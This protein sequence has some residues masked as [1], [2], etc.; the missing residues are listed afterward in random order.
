[1]PEDKS[2]FFYGGLFHWLFDRPLAEG[3]QVVTD[4]IPEGSSV[5]DIGSG[6][7]LLCGALAAKNCRVIGL[8]LSLRMLRYAQ[9]HNRYNDVRFVHGDATDLSDFPDHSFEYATLLFVLHELPRQ[10]QVR[11]LREAVRVASTLVMVDAKV[12]LPKNA[13][14]RGIRLVESTFGRD[15][16][17]NFKAFLAG[18]GIMGAL[19]AAALPAT[20]S[21]RSVFWRDCREVVV[22]SRVQ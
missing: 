9:K 17:P 12:P 5:L 7:G 21:H 10:T 22:A 3:R 11:V 2:L 16:Y 19:E 4:L 18:G 14:A 8:D 6:T 13:G 1:M 15:H 20:V